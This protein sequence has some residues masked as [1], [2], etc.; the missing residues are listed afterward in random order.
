MNMKTVSSPTESSEPRPRRH[1]ILACVDLSPFT[2][3]C[4]P[5]AVSLARAL[6][7]DLTLIHV[8]Q[9][10]HEYEGGANVN[11]L[12]WEISRQQ[13]H[14]HLERLKKETAQ[15]LNHPVDI[16][17][18]QGHP[19]ERIVE[20]ER[21]IHADLTVLASHGESGVTPWDLG[22]TVYQVL[23]VSRR[24]VFIAHAAS[25]TPIA[26]SPKRIIVPLDGSQRTECVLPIATRIARACDAELILVHVIREQVPTS[27]LHA[28]EDL[29]LAS[30]LASHL[31]ITAKTYLEGLRAALE[32]DGTV[33]RTLV[34]RNANQRR[35]IIEVAKNE[36]ADFI[37]VAAHGDACDGD[38]TH[39][40][41]TEY[42]LTHSQ[43]PVLM[44]QDRPEAEMQRI[45]FGEV[46]APP[47]RASFLPELI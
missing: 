15:A 43:V 7:S 24:S 2:D 47:L 27:V 14:C 1:Q 31:E 44:L 4:L 17:L 46:I 35:A 23:A 21:E 30:K 3:V 28:T 6:Q 12:D 34:V 40:S 33:V 11:A 29:E 9:P 18:E 25:A 39:G 32:R 16:R 26:T 38:C 37:V 19:A 45:D 22:S 20:V 36:R 8:M 5:Y 10:R 13:A 41:V 42:L